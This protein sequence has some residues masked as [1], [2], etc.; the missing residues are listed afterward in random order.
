MEESIIL[1][2]NRHWIELMRY[3]YITDERQLILRGDSA[4]NVKGIYEKVKDGTVMLYKKRGRLHFQ[5]NEKEICLEDDGRVTFE[6]LDRNNYFS[7]EK[8]GEVFFSITYP[9]WRF[10]PL[11]L[12][13]PNFS[14]SMEED[15]DIYLFIFN[16]MQNKERQKRVFTGE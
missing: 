9:S 16:L 13:D 14:D 10:D 3:N 5:F 2:N 11:N 1:Q 6:R 4:I 12:V 15:Q 8:S 7:I